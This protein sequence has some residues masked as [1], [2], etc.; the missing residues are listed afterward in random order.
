MKILIDKY[1][2]K[3][4]GNSNMTTKS[5]ENRSAK[6]QYAKVGTVVVLTP[7]NFGSWKGHLQSNF[8]LQTY[9]DPGHLLLI[10]HKRELGP[11]P[12]H[13]GDDFSLLAQSFKRPLAKF[14][15]GIIF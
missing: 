6:K 3:P 1:V 13:S 5:G 15:I 11:R 9:L 10:V 12:N 7:H 14:A 4:R 2:Q 8:R